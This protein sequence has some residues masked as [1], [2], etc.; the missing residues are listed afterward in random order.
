MCARATLRHNTH[1]LNLFSKPMRPLASTTRSHSR[2][3][4]IFCID[5]NA[6]G[7][8]LVRSVGVNLF[9]CVV[10][11]GFFFFLRALP[12]ECPRPASFFFLSSS[13][14]RSPRR[15]STCTPWW[16]WTL[17]RTGSPQ[18]FGVGPTPFAVRTGRMGKNVSGDAGGLYCFCSDIFFFNNP[19]F[20]RLA[21][22][23][24]ITRSQVVANVKKTTK[25]MAVA[26]VCFVVFGNFSLLGFV[27]RCD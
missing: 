14:H 8:V 26:F 9:V 21:K 3:N 22:F 5:P 10:V 11:C 6:K 24:N 19:P 20:C 16:H 15:R 7:E 27:H 23:S 1:T 13:A 4:T 17:E 25:L 18:T 2:F 12:A